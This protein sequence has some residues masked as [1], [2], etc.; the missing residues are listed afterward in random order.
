MARLRSRVANL[1]TAWVL[2]VHLVLLPALYFGVGYVIRKSHE[3]LFVQHARTFARILADEFE[4]GAALESG[5]RTEDLLDLAIIHGESRY[6]ELVEHDHTIRSALGPPDITAPHEPD[7]RFAHGGDD[8]YFIVLPIVHAGQN[9]ELR[10]GFDERP[11]QA[12]IQLAL[13]RMLLLMT[14]YLCVAVGIATYLSNRL[15]RPIRRLQ[16]VS[17]SIASGDYA[18][19]LHVSTGIREL[20]ELAAD[21][22]A[23]RRELVGVNDRLQEKI[24][25]KEISETRRDELQKQLRHRQRLETVGTLAGG[26]AHEFNNVLVPIILF[27]D[28]ALQDLPAG[29]ASHSD[30]ERVLASA[31]RAKNIVQKILTFSH[32]L[33]DTT[34]A[35]IDLRTVV[36]ESVVLFSALAPPSIEIRTE[37]AEHVPLVRADAT[38]AMDLVMNLC[39]NAYQAMQG[40]AG[41][42]SIGLCVLPSTTADGMPGVE[43]RVA[44]TGHGMEQPTVERIFE[45]FFTTRPVGQGTGLGLS[46]VHGIV[47]SFGASITVETAPGAGTTFRILFPAIA[48]LTQAARSSGSPGT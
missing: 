42:L 33:G 20:H 22:E 39:T 1:V 44:D 45:P 23:M 17:R 32:V 48:E 5:A 27:T 7:M 3:D 47:E 6:A 4:V 31:R 19:A 9:A 29:S 43:L 8:I 26:I 15:S 28:T 46:V 30:L 40:T 37:I 12:R 36:T 18:Q 35:P 24:R 41:I 16:D 10:L 11:T 21:L 38:L 34:L 25:E 2:A 14:G 13:N